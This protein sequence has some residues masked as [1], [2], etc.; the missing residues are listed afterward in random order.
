MWQQAGPLAFTLFA[1]WFSTGA[2][3]WLAGLRQRRATL[4]VATLLLAAMLGLLALPPG[5]GP[6]AAY[7][8]FSAA[9]AVWGWQELAFLLGAVTGPRRTPC[10]AGA[11]GWPRV[12][13][14]LQVVLH[15]EIAL[16][17]LAAALWLLAP[18]DRLPVAW[19][20]FAALWAMRQSAKL[21]LF[22]GVRQLNEQFLP[23]QLA[24][25]AS[26]FRRRRWNA[27]LPW[28]L[29]GIGAATVLAWRAALDGGASAHDATAWALLATLLTLG[30]VEHVLLVLPMPSQRLWAWGLRL[31]EERRAGR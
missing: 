27:L 2:I 26:Y 5:D 22:L 30:W 29:L 6:R 28:S 10:P 12:L 1:W 17:L 31:R 21:N 25:V 18:A 13:L 20:T 9:L 8:A 3:L 7:V 24:H 23:P 19:W 11:T 14:A 15:H 16:L 4:A